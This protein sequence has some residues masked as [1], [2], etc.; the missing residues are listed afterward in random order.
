MFSVPSAISR[1]GTPWL[2]EWTGDNIMDWSERTDLGR[3]AQSGKPEALERLLTTCQA[4][5]RRYAYRHCV[6]NDIDDAI[7]E[8]LMVVAKKVQGIKAAAAFTSWLSTVI[9]RECRRLE[10][11]VSRWDPLVE[12]HFRPNQTD[13]TLRLDLTAALESLP[14]HYLEIVLLRDFEE[15]TIGEISERLQEPAGAVKSRLHRARVLVR[16][17]MLETSWES[18]P[19]ALS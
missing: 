15:L 7:Q 5:A 4:D 10:K 16:E 3:A 2:R 1:D 13:E 17:Y 18:S 6:A 12:A 11:V 14:A 8:A 19:P 9:R